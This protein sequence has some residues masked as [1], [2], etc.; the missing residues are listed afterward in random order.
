MSITSFLPTSFA[1]ETAPAT[2]ATE[3]APATSNTD[4][5]TTTQTSTSDASRA[6]ADV[7]SD[8]DT[9]IQLLTAQVQNQDPL[10]P[11]DST[12]FVEQLAT[13]S[14][15]EQQVRGNQSLERME[16]ILADLQTMFAT[17]WLG[18]DVAVESKWLPYDG[19]AV[20]FN[21]EKNKQAD[22]TVL[23]I[24]TTD[25]QT[26]WEKSVR[27]SEEAITW[28]GQTQAG[29]RVP[30]DTLLQ[31]SVDSKKDGKTFASSP[32]KIVTEV[33]GVAS[34]FGKLRLGT[35]MN[36]SVDVENVEKVHN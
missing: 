26:V 6:A 8:F 28:N 24:K 19:Q 3:A 14:A 9:F 33:T 4:G 35:A 20:D 21:V 15:L 29:G 7:A 1:K 23:S 36:M 2:T 32:A 5:A 11:L 10:E 17:E 12:Q 18:Q 13:F 31:V 34:E 22:Q 25:G 27:G 16:V 30:P